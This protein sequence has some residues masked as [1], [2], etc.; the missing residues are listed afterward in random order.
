MAAEEVS[1]IAEEALFNAR[2]HAEAEQIDLSISYGPKA[3]IVA[4]KDDGKG[5][6]SEILA[7]GERTGHFGLPGMRERAERL[8][9]GLQ[10]DSAPGAG[11]RIEVSIPAKAAYVDHGKGSRSRRKRES[12][13]A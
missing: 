8:G 5:I 10:I 7:K 2:R 9:G 6:D 1:R 13:D 11:T 4:I 3:L 12:E